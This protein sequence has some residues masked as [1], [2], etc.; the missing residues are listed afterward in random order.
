MPPPMLRAVVLRFLS[1]HLS[2]GRVAPRPR[3]GRPQ[4]V[5]MLLLLCLL[6]L[7]APRVTTGQAIR[8]RTAREDWVY[9]LGCAHGFFLHGGE[10][11]EVVRWWG[12]D[13]NSE[14][15][16]RLMCVCVDFG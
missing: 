16:V 2:L 5:H 9:C 8:G 11:R 15:L 4:E 14:T 12:G 13:A 10:V 3:A 6:R 7:S 1:L